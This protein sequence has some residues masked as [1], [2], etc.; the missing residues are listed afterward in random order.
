MKDE[1]TKYKDG[2]STERFYNTTTVSYFI[3]N[4]DTL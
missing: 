4:D 3:N 1:S 2:Y